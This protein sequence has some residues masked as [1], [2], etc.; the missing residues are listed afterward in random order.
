M[1]NDPT[2]GWARPAN[3]A[4]WTT[5]LAGTGIAN[6]D[7]SWDCTIGAGNLSDQ[8]GSLTLTAGG[9]VSYAQ[10]ATGWSGTG[11]SGTDGVAGRFAA[12]AGVGPDPDVTSQVWLVM[13]NLAS[14]PLA[15]IRAAFGINLTNSA[16]A[17]RMLFLTSGSV[18]AAFNATNVDGAV[19]HP[20]GDYVAVMRYDRA[21]TVAKVYTDLET[22]T[23]VYS[24]VNLTDNFKGI[25]SAGYPGGVVFFLVA[26]WEGANAETLDDTKIAT[27]RSRIEAP[28]GGSKGFY[29]RHLLKMM[30]AD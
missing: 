19:N 4:E 16:N 12:A 9:T 25:G 18:R 2:K 29:Y 27:I 23:N 7:H 24:A 5:L 1:P 20:A 26:M 22:L 15:A 10:A 6:P 13:F 3:A 17:Y 14:A 21:A 11:V 28:P 30:G 8:I